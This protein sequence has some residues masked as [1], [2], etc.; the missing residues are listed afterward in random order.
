MMFLPVTNHAF[1]NIIFIQTAFDH[2]DNLQ[3]ADTKVQQTSVY[4]ECSPLTLQSQ[5]GGHRR[6]LIPLPLKFLIDWNKTVETWKS[7][8][9]QLAHEFINFWFGIFYEQGFPVILFIQPITE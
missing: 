3:A 4:G 5:G 2:I 1:Y 8:G 7:P 9:N 6:D